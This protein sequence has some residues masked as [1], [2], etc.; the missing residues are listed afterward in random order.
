MEERRSEPLLE[1]PHK[2]PDGC[3]SNIEFG[4]R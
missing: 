1:C 3:G 4:R 2:L